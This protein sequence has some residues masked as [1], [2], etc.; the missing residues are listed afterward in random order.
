MKYILLFLISSFTF[1]NSITGKVV[2]ISDGDTFTLL[3]EKNVQYRIRLAEIDAPEN[4]QPFGKAAKKQLSDLIFD[5]IVRVDY[6]E[7][8][9]YGRIIGKVYL[10]KVYISEEMIRTGYAWHYKRYSNSK[11]LAAIETEAKKNKLGVWSVTGAIAPW[12]WRKK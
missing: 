4:S 3:D 11:K 7:Y 2:S 12:E 1:G 6:T 8:D 10:D 5:K 9:L